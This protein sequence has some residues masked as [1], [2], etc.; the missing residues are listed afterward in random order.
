MG[1]HQ[2]LRNDA[3]SSRS[4]ERRSRFSSTNRRQMPSTLVRYT[5]TSSLRYWLSRQRNGLWG[6]SLQV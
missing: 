5:R 4:W 1:A 6:F 2:K 3:G